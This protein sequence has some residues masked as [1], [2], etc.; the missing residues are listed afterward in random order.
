MASMEEKKQIIMDHEAWF[1]RNLSHKVI[2]KPALALW[3][4][5][6]PVFF[7]FFMLEFQR[8][9]ASRKPFVADYL[10]ARQRAMEA[11]FRLVVDGE[12]P[13][14]ETLAGL[15][16]VPEPV[17]KTHGEWLKVAIKHY[18]SLLRADG[19]DFPS[20]ARAAYRNKTNLMLA[21]NLLGEAEK[22]MD[23][24]LVP[25]L[26]DEVEDVS[27]VVRNMQGASEI[28]RRQVAE[29]FFS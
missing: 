19:V 22:N 11:A 25:H 29:E 13:D 6:I 27:E 10:K 17:R 28:L 15:S 8:A 2:K 26:I 14:M 20:M 16:D 12:E 7:V 5:L 21:Y 23:E 24:A 18:C 3:M 4:I 1:A 9:N